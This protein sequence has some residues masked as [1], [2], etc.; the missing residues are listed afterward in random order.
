M[1][2]LNRLDTGVVV[3]IMAEA[4]HAEMFR[5]RARENTAQVRQLIEDGARV[6]KSFASLGALRWVVVGDE[7]SA[8]RLGSWWQLYVNLPPLKV[9]MQNHGS[10]VE[11]FQTLKDGLVGILP[12]VPD[13]IDLQTPWKKLVEFAL[14][15]QEWVIEGSA[16]RYSREFASAAA[17]IGANV[18]DAVLKPD[19]GIWLA[20]GVHRERGRLKNVGVNRKKP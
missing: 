9:V 14:G 18:I 1:T 2:L 3:T 20:L 6:E 12:S 7:R 10:G 11:F 15:T 19:V 8:D 13:H 16:E 17:K 5:S 4:K